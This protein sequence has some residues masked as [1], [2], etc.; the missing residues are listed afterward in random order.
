MNSKKDRILDEK[1]IKTI[2]SNVEQILS[3]NSMLLQGMYFFT[4]IDIPEMEN[5]M[6]AFPTWEK[7]SIGECF[8]KFSPFL[9]GIFFSKYG[10]YKI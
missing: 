9:K 4:K 7:G 10:I 3:I 2:F 8:A 5:C 1:E 6:S